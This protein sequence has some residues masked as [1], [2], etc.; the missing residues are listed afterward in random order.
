MKLCSLFTLLCSQ[1]KVV[2]EKVIFLEIKHTLVQVQILFKVVKE[3]RFLLKKTKN[4]LKLHSF[5]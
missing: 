2:T 3:M 5:I 1:R 4:K